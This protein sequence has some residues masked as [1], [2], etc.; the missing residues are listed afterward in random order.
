M[1]NYEASLNEIISRLRATR[2]KETAYLALS[3]LMNSIAIAALLILLVSAV[4]SIAGGDQAFR[5]VLAGILFVGFVMSMGILVVPAILRG[6]WPH[7]QPYENE[8]A[9]R[10]GR[11]YPDVKDKLINA[12]Q[13]VAGAAKAR[14]TSP[15]LAFGA[16]DIIKVAVDAKNFDAIIDRNKL[17]RSILFFALSLFIS[18]ASFGVFQ[19]SLGSSFNRIVNFTQS[20]LPPVPFR[21]S[22]SPINENILR[23]EKAMITVKA[24]GQPPEYINLKIKENQQENYDE[25]K[26]RLD[27]GNTYKYEIPSLK[28][29]LTFFAEA[30]WLSSVVTT[31]IGRINVVT[32]PIVRSLS[33]RIIQPAYTGLSAK[34]FN[35]QSAD[36]SA[37]IG[38]AVDFTIFANKELD[39]AYLVFEEIKTIEELQRNEL[40]RNELQR[41]ELESTELESTESESMEI[42]GE[43]SETQ[44]TESSTAAANKPKIATQTY[45]IPLKTEGRK[46]A[47]RLRIRSSGNYYFVVKD[48]EGQ[49]NSEPIKYSMIALNDAFPS[50][51]LI[52]PTVDVQ[53]SEDALLPIRT[54]ISDDYGFSSLKLHYRLAHSEYTYP[55]KEFTAVEIGIYSDE[56][57]VEVPYIWS[58]LDLGISPEDRYEFYLEVFDNDIISGPKSAKTQTLTVRLPSL[59]EILSEVKDDQENIREE[60]MKALAEAQELKKDMEELKN[61][62]RKNYKKKKLNWEEKKK[63]KNILKKQEDI[64]NKMSEI[65]DNLEQATRKM[66]QNNLLSQ[67]TLM[68]YM[69]LQRLMEQIDS[70]QLRKMQQKM[71]EAME[72]MSPQQLQKAMEELEFNEEQFKK[73]IERTMKILKR[74]LAEQKADALTKQAEELAKKQEELKKQTEST[75]PNDAKKKEELTKKQEKLSKELEEMAKNLDELEDLM[76]EIGDEM[77]MD[78]MEKAK[79]EL[80]KNETQKAMQDAQKQTKKGDMQKAANKQSKASKNL[81]QFAEQ[82]KKMKEKMQDKVS[83]EA[84]RKLQKAISDLLELSKQQENLKEQSKNSDYNSTQIPNMAQ[85]QSNMEE[86]LANLANSLMELANKTFAITPEMASEI[87]KAMQQMQKA[88]EQYASRNPKQASKEQAGAMASLNSAASQMQSMLSMMKQNGGSCNNPGGSGMGKQGQNGGMSFQQQMQQ[89]A[90]QQQMINQSLQQMMQSGKGGQMSEEKRAELGRL[91]EKQ[92][93]AQKSLDELAKEQKEL[94]GNQRKTLGDLS[95]ISEDMKEIISDLKTGNVNRQTLERQDRILSRLLDA[96][97]S[98]HDRDYEKKRESK[99][100]KDYTRQSPDIPDLQTARGRAKALKELIKSLRQG[101]TKDYEKLIMRYFEA[102]KNIDAGQQEQ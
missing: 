101:Y 47:G 26:L 14:G 25:L 64:K 48:T 43:E 67:E 17:K 33:G 37:L 73:S 3:G 54:A 16:F 38:S 45:S 98:V 34:T 35:E 24:D 72:N 7:N 51:T 2:L 80:N 82:M 66:Q 60:L 93:K 4:E 89:L 36:I 79:Q 83:K 30:E 63:L 13:V 92:G 18:G 55:D 40:Q 69:E 46:A 78:E 87:G 58:L 57:A 31:E 61:D 41:N 94:G 75:N 50:I 9:E 99:S 23:G 81:K 6:I 102:L 21:L 77:P 96:T 49:F 8:I 11:I 74:M 52:E 90:G 28:K 20:Y 32:R 5:A 1:S 44:E 53:V 65:K 76:K 22:I 84:M 39:S 100:G 10:V 91:S 68:K 12:I 42:E 88:M 59:S 70:D 19:S 29:S 95:K 71:Q 15:E 97:R 86:A 85:N 56:L 62:L 27:T